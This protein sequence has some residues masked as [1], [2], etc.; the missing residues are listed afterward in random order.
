MGLGLAMEEQELF[1]WKE[2]AG[3]ETELLAAPSQWNA[4]L[5][6]PCLVGSFLPGKAAKQVVTAV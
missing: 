1:S 6:G 2:M 5:C 4:A 3:C